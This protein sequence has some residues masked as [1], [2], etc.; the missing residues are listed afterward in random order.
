[1]YP[2]RKY[3]Q[4]SVIFTGRILPTERTFAIHHYDGSP[5]LR[6]KGSILWT[7]TD[8]T[9]SLMYDKKTVY[10]GVFHALYRMGAVA[11]MN[12]GLILACRNEISTV[13]RKTIWIH[14]LSIG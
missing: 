12:A 4:V 9:E 11:A 5:E 8:C 14:L 13:C 6:E 3:R 10:Q 7:G 1:M 2:E